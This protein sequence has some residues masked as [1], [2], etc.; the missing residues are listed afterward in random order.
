MMFE[1]DGNL[2]TP[3]FFN[4]TSIISSN[5]KMTTFDVPVSFVPL[6]NSV[7]QYLLNILNGPW[8]PLI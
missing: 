4:S 7:K 8:R 5:I 1:V 3:V 6:L 2:I